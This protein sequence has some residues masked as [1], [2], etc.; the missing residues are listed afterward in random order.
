MLQ[1]QRDH[2]LRPAATD[3]IKLCNLIDRV[4]YG[5]V[6]DFLDFY[7]GRYHWPAFNLADSFITVGVTITLYY[8]IRFKDQDPFAAN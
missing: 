6:I 3:A 5:E 1:A 7:W 2:S 8:L 4:L